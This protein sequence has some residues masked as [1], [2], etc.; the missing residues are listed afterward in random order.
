MGLGPSIQPIQIPLQSLPTLLQFNTPAHLSVVHELTEDALDPLICIINKG[1]EQDNSSA[2]PF[3]T[4][5]D[6]PTTGCSTIHH[7]SLGFAIQPDFYPVNSAPVQA[8]SNCFLW[9][10][11]VRSVSKTLLRCR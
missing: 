1:I 5:C 8:K 10:N 6:L 9:E 7:H 4:S 11:A 3:G 2:E